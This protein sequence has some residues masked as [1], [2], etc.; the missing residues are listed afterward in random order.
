MIAA[1]FIRANA[2]NQCHSGADPPDASY[3][4]TSSRRSAC[5]ALEPDLRELGGVAEQEEPA[6]V[7]PRVGDR[8]DLPVDD[9][10]RRLPHARM[11]P[12]R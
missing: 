1:I 12:N 8:P 11:F 2:R 5:R 7:D 6:E 10:H 4:S 3:S 9:A